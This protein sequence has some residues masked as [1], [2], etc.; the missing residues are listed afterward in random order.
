MIVG[1]HYQLRKLNGDLNVAVNSQQLTR[2]TNYR[3]LGI[4]V[5]EA[6]GW[7]SQVDII[8]TK[9]S[10]GIGALKCIRSLVP[11]QT[12]LRMYDALVAPSF[13]YCSEV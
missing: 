2:V 5:D 3:Y 7:Q 13:A 9:V 6:S 1:S 11:R 4:E 10:A 8:S 12:L